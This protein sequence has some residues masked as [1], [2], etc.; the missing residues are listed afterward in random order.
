MRTFVSLI[1]LSLL[2]VVNAAQIVVT[3]GA[4]STVKAF[5]STW[6]ICLDL[7]PNPAHL[8][9]VVCDCGKG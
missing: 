5:L 4:N 6:K 1:A 2:A 8:S 3:V 7:L 9:T